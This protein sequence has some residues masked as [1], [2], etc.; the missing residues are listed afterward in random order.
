M[1]H[2]NS[3]MKQHGMA[4]EAIVPREQAGGQSLPKG[5]QRQPHRVITHEKNEEVD[6]SKKVKSQVRDHAPVLGL[7]TRTA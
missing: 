5:Q 1:T 3:N 4:R 6:P 7:T 2:L